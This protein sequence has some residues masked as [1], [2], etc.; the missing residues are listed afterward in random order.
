MISPSLLL[1]NL[2]NKPQNLNK[3]NYE[4]DSISKNVGCPNQGFE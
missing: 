3:K 2:L 4:A 1:T